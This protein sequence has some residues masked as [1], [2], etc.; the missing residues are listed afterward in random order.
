MFLLVLYSLSSIFEN[1]SCFSS[2][3]G[4]KSLLF[5]GSYNSF[6]YVGGI[7]KSMKAVILG[8]IVI[9][10]IFAVVNLSQSMT[11]ASTA[12]RQCMCELTDYDYYGNQMGIHRIPIDVKTAGGQDNCASRCDAFF[13]RSSDHVTGYPVPLS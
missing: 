13:G 7:V 12:V 3:S 6:L 11:G 8:I 10:G 2:M 9:V 5:L 1:S 4:Y